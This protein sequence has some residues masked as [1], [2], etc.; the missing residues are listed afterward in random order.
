MYIPF[1]PATLE[2]GT[3][4]L[5]LQFLPICEVPREYLELLDIMPKVGHVL[6]REC[7]VCRRC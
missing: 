2:F 6:G 1:M 4:D 3:C 7:I 5:L